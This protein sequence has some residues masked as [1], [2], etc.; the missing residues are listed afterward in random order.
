[1]RF[2][3]HP[4]R[5]TFYGV[6]V[7]AIAYVLL[8]ILPY[9][10]RVY[11]SDYTRNSF[12]INNFF[13]EHQTPERVMLL[14]DPQES[15]FHRVNLISMA[16]QQIAIA[17]YVFSQGDS[18]DIIVGA[19][20]SAAERGVEVYI[21]GDGF[22]G[23]MP[24]AYRNILASHENINL[25]MFSRLNLLQP[26]AIN[27]VFHDKYMTVDNQFLILGGRNI[28][29]RFFTPSGTDRR[30]VQDREV[31]VYNNDTTHTGII[32]Q[33]NEYF[34][35]K[36]TSP[37]VTQ[38]QSRGNNI[39]EQK[40]H[41][42]SLYENHQNSHNQ[43]FDYLTN[44]VYTNKITLIANPISTAKKEG[45]VA[46]NLLMLT[47]NSNTIVAQTPYIVL[48][49]RNLAMLS[50]AAYDRDVTISTNSLASTTNIPAFSN[51]HAIR[52][53]LVSA[54]IHIYEYQDTNSSLH[55]KTYIFDNRLV[56]IGSFNLNERSIRSDTESMLVIDSTAF[57]AITLTAIES[58]ISNSL[59]VAQNNRYIPN[60]H[61][62]EARVSTVKRVLYAIVGHGMRPVRFLS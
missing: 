49:N 21:I 28:G 44:T 3:T 15:F 36:R 25:Y 59:R 5:T 33:V 26:R 20:L 2:R 19:L 42:I 48:T 62:D 17:T 38:I 1:M 34:H 16:N 41:F 51:Y 52:R 29:D 31:L 24:L 54:G 50:N 27:T 53:R 32:A 60:P 43:N 39:S 6:F 58:H 10:G 35:S 9:I 61:V 11:V 12:S 13:G 4:V 40:N 56:A 7:L 18:G 46:Y 30:F 55:G 37:Y 47:K 8:V 22:T 23:Q 14:E 57:A 45:L